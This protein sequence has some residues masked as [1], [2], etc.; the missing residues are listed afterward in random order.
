LPIDS[1]N[2]NCPKCKC[3]SVE[4][5][6]SRFLGIVKGSENRTLDCIVGASAEKRWQQYEQRRLKRKQNVTTK[7]VKIK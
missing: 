5:L 7:N 3:E 4:K 1:K 2:P 6:V